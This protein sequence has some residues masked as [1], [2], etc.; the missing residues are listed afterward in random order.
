MDDY[1]RFLRPRTTS[2]NFLLDMRH[3]GADLNIELPSATTSR[4]MASSKCRK[5]LTIEQT[6]AV[7]KAMGHSAQTDSRHYQNVGEASTA[8]ETFGLLR[9][10]LVSPQKKKP[11]VI[12]SSSETEGETSHEKPGP[13]RTLFSQNQD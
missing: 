8:H 2:K 13:S 10:V 12:L 3:Q 11:I 6:Y 5:K 1:V 4:K 9:S 7:A